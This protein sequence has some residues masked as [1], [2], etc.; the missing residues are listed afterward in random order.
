MR[1]TTRTHF[2]MLEYRQ[3]GAECEQMTQTAVS[4]SRGL[5]VFIFRMD[6]EQ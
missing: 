1:T 5:D 6:V 2:R 3:N 4:S